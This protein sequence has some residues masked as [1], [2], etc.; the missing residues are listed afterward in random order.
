MKSDKEMASFYTYKINEWLCVRANNNYT[1][2]FFNVTL[3]FT[4]CLSRLIQ[5]LP[6][7]I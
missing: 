6:N 1:Y 7:F 5:L 4:L 2:S 3:I